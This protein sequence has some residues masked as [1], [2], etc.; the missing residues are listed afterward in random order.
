MLRQMLD[1]ELFRLSEHSV[2]VATV[3]TAFVVLIVSWSLSV[4]LQRGVSRTLARRGLAR[5]GSIAVTQRLLH[6]T[7]MLVGTAIALETIGIS[8]GA[9]FAAGAIFAIGLG[10]AMQNIAQNFVSGLILLVER[11]I[12]PGDVLEVEGIMVRAERMGIR[13]TLARTMDDEEL[14]I[15]SSVLVQSTVKNF[16][17]HDSLLRVRATV[18][19]VYSSDV[20]TVFETLRAVTERAEWRSQRRSPVVVLLGFGSSSVDFEVSVWIDDPWEY[21]SAR[22][23]L[24]E[25]IW[26][27]LKEAGTVIAFPQLDVHFD[28]VVTQA[29]RVLGS[30]SSAA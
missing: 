24:Y 10:F 18:G 8:L 3:L 21:R 28:P 4:A 27:G 25:A 11:S 7:A 1:F 15:P 22:S 12:K 16:T 9:L 17:L 20:R 26:W 14:I 23:R 13:A 30:G 6:Y 2:T 19:V 29:A 5:E